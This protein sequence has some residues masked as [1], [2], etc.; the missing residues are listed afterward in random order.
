MY[1]LMILSF[2]FLGWG[3]YEL[4][5]GPEFRPQ[6]TPIAAPILVTEAELVNIDETRL[7]IADAVADVAATDS[8]GAPEIVMRSSMDFTR[9]AGVTAGADGR[10]G[11][12]EIT[13]IALVSRLPVETPE[14]DADLREVTASRLNM[15]GGP[16]TG[17]PVLATLDRG[18]QVE[19]IA[20]N[21]SWVQ[22]RTGGRTGWMASKLLSE[23]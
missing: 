17:H 3:F 9:P 10:D 2:L 23:I 12:E 13:D 15:R 14:A 7:L 5:G 11:L 16:G 21:G 8:F 20:E 4:S 1:R 18:T 19:V 22:V 6:E